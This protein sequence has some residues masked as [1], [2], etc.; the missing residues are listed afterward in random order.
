M[1]RPNRIDWMN[2][3]DLKCAIMGAMGFSSQYISEETG[4]SSGQIQYRLNK[5][6]IKRKDYR[7]GKSD[8]AARVIERMTPG[9]GRVIRQTLNLN[10]KKG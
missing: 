6:S 9:S 1:K 7:N 3:D 2:D 10:A 8:M 5:G 4:L